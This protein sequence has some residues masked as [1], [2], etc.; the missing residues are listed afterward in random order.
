M[1]LA[2]VV[3]IICVGVSYRQTVRAYPSG[4]GSYIV[5]TDNLGEVAGLA[6]AA[7]LIIDYVLTVAVLGNHGVVSVTSAIPSLRSDTVLLGVLVIALLLAGNLR[8]VR[9]AGNLFALP[10]YLF[11]LA[12]AALI[13]GGFVRRPTAASRRCRHPTSPPLLS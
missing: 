3:L 6:A 13:V 10:T 9:Q 4:A 12:M 8:G 2:L 7:G 11:L 5:A 1:G